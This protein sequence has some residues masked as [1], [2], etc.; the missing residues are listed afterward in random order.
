M[1]CKSLWIKA[2]AKYIN[3]NVIW[4]Q[5][6][7]QRVEI[8]VY[9]HSCANTQNTAQIKQYILNVHLYILCIPRLLEFE[10]LILEDRLINLLI[11]FRFLFK[12]LTSNLTV[13]IIVAIYLKNTTKKSERLSYFQ[14]ILSLIFM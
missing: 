2:S 13:H 11:L 1:H 7:S 10:I 12:L 3:V 6:L 4:V 9:V 8:F 5:L 14:A